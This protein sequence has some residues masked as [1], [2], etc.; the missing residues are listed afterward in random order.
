LGNHGPNLGRKG[1]RKAREKMSQG[2]F[3]RTGP[4][5]M[6]EG[7]M[8]RE[9]FRDS[10]LGGGNWSQQRTFKRKKRRRF[11]SQ[12]LDNTNEHEASWGE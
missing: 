8:R 9:M 3:P 1:V 12:P 10:L 2:I 7:A 4:C 5:L 11:V 6:G